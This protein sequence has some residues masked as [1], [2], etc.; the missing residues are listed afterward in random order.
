M[1]NWFGGGDKKP[2]PMNPSPQ[3]DVKCQAAVKAAAEALVGTGV[4]ITEVHQQARQNAADAGVSCNIG[5]GHVSSAVK[6]A[7]KG[8]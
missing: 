7:G 5:I 1:G 2:E 3:L 6:D 4:R 8:R